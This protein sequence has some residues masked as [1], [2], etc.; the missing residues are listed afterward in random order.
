MTDLY[1]GKLTTVTLNAM[2]VQNALFLGLDCKYPAKSTINEALGILETRLPDPTDRPTLKYIALGNAGHRPGNGPHGISVPKP[3]RHKANNSGAFAFVPWA[4]RPV[5]NDFTDDVRGDYALRRMETHGTRR[6]WAYYLKRID[7][8]GVTTL[9][10]KI[11]VEDGV[12]T[13]VE[14][15]YTDSELFPTAPALPSHDFDV[16]DRVAVPDGE[17]VLSNATLDVRMQSFDAYEFLNVARV[18]YDDPDAA[19]I[20]EVVLCTGL[21][22]TAEGESFD[23]SPF[24]YNEAI[25]VQAAYLMT[26][27]NNIAITNDRLTYKFKIGQSIPFFLGTNV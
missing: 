17:Y 9:D 11:T 8:R 23:G 2:R 5:E 20:S 7:M 25:G 1:D 15:Q 21:D 24:N 16:E 13:P 4:L 12:S 6:Y 22:A 3:V 10:Y 27:F 26:C 19:I 14:H 18:L